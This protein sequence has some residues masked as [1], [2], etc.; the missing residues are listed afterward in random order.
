MLKVPDLLCFFE[1]FLSIKIKL[2]VLCAKTHN[3]TMFKQNIYT[4]KEE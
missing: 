3:P 1:G 4:N 2:L